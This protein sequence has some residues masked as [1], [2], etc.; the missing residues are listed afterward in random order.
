MMRSTLTI[1][2]ETRP[3]EDAKS[4]ALRAN[5]LISLGIGQGDPREDSGKIFKGHLKATQR[6]GSSRVKLKRSL[7]D[8]SRWHQ[9]HT[10]SDR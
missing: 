3:A 2:T 7:H 4:A 8:H 5:A 6:S 9:A 10:R 1:G